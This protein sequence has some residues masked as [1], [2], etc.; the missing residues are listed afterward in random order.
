MIRADEQGNLY[1][2]SDNSGYFTI[3]DIPSVTGKLS[4]VFNGDNDVVKYFDVNG[5][6]E[7][8]IKLTKK[9]IEDIGIGTHRWYADL[10]Y[11]DEK[12]TIVYQTITVVEKDM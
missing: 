9:D 3:K 1:V 7:A 4:V 10:Q 8:V 6:T 5:Q 12:D 2:L 11:E